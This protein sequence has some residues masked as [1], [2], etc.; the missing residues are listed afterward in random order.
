MQE[1]VYKYSVFRNMQI[2]HLHMKYSCTNNRG[3]LNDGFVR[4][5]QLDI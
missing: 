2:K 3:Y 4:I 5:N 1:M